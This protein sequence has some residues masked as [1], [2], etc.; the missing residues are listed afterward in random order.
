[1]SCWCRAVVVIKVVAF[2]FGG[3]QV[4][5]ASS[6]VKALQLNMR[7]QMHLGSSQYHQLVGHGS[8]AADQDPSRPITSPIPLHLMLGGAIDLS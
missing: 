4:A 2:I 1:M 8:L 3:K 5:V 7:G 6:A